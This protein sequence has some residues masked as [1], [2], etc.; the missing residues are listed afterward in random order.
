M[1]HLK[2]FEENKPELNVGDI[3]LYDGKYI[4][5]VLE[6]HPGYDLIRIRIYHKSLQYTDSDVST[7][8]CEKFEEK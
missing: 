4:G 6:L 5:K 8:W 1:K 2:V 3:V 7:Y